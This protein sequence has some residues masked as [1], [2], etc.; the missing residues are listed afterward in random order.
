MRLKGSGEAK[1]S[2]NATFASPHLVNSVSFP[3][4]ISRRPTQD[5]P[6]I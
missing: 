3:K 2:L 6:G 5:R 4:I 1:S